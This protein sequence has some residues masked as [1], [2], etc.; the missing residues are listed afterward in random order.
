MKLTFAVPVY[1]N[2]QA[3]TL[4]YEKTR[5]LIETRFADFECEWVFVDDGS[6]D[7]SLQELLG[8]RERDPRVKVVSFTRNFGQMAAILAGLNQVTGDVAINMSADLQEPVELIE[9]MI[10]S[11]R[12][13][14]ELVIAHRQG[15]RDSWLER[16]TSKLA[17]GLIR[18]SIPQIPIGGFDFILMDRKVVNSFNEIRVRNRFLQGDLLWFGYSTHFIPYTRLRRTI[19]R[20]QYTFF[21]RLKNFTDAMLDASYLPIRFISA[22][23]IVTAILGFIYAFDIVYARWVGNVP[24]TGWAPIMVLILV[25]GGLIMFMLGIIGEY[26]WRIYDETRQKPNYVIR[27]TY[28]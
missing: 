28:L 4:T 12:S 18:L 7:N 26:V 5:Q 21:K 11:W 6:T 17:Y 22:T 1:Q 8:L 10:A 27:R 19:G 13:G 3:L 25:V 2:E 16:V 23:G 20:S 15:R 9:Q 24:F 14:A